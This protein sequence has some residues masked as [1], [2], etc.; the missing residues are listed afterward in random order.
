MDIV[1]ELLGHGALPNVKSKDGII[2]VKGYCIFYKFV[3]HKGYVPILWAAR[4]GHVDVVRTLLDNGA[5]TNV[6][7]NAGNLKF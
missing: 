1:Q 2:I 5:L 4:Q 7:D 6:V 3:I